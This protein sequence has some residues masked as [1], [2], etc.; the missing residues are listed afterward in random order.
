MAAAGA[1]L[2]FVERRDGQVKRPS[3]E[4][5]S[6]ARRL[7]DARGVEVEALAFGPGA[8]GHAELLGMHGADRLLTAEDPHLELYAPEAYAATLAEVARA[9]RAAA[10]LVPG[11]TMGRDLAPRA[12]ARLQ[13][14]CLSDVVEIERTADGT[15]RGKRPVYS[16]KA[17]A[18]VAIPR[19][20]PAMATLRP[21]VFPAESRARGPAEVVAVESALPADRIRVR[22]T[23][24]EHAAQQELDVAEAA[25]IVSGGRGLKGPEN[26]SLVRDL[27][28]ALGGAVGASRAVVDEGWIPHAHQVGQ[29]GKVVSPGL[30]VACGISGA[31]QHLAGMSTSKVIVAINKDPEAPIFK[32]AD[33]GIVGDVFEVLPKLTRAIRELKSEG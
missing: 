19:A 15:L 18:R 10:V 14:G 13:T 33:Y 28:S 22:T 24:V 2:V 11:T 5:V 9:R 12:A 32:V 27:A 3:L 29:T 23:R 4:A 21:N 1:I 16:G 17:Y 6:T 31:I 25:V 8:G 7:A 20:R 30:Y 26:F